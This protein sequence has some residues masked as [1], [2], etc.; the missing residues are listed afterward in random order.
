MM[1]NMCL[2]QSDQ[3]TTLVSC[4]ECGSALIFTQNDLGTDGFDAM[5]RVWPGPLRRLSWEIPGALRDEHEEALQCFEANAY[6]A[7]VVM[8]RRTLEGVASVNGIK[9]RNLMQ[10]LAK[11]QDKGVLDPRLFEWSQALRVLGNEG[12]HFTGKKVSR[13]DAADALA[14]SEAILDYLYVLSAKFE[15][16]KKRRTNSAKTDQAAAMGDPR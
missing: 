3:R 13:E 4:D 1:A 9:E 8:V 12:A 7:A 14:L 16:F 15:E 6:T 5:E 10:S 2:C 11:M